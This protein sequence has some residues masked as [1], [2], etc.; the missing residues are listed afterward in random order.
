MSIDTKRPE[1][2]GSSQEQKHNLINGCILP[3]IFTFMT[4]GPSKLNSMDFDIFF[5]FGGGGGGGG[6]GL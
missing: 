3:L 2:P 5:F 6:G 1:A 4:D